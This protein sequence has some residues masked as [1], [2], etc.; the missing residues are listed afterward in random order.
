MRNAE[1]QFL[2]Q[3]EVTKNVLGKRVWSKIF[4]LLFWKVQD[5]EWNCVVYE[6][7]IFEKHSK[8]SV[9]NK[10]NEKSMF[11]MLGMHC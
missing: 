10:D 5:F 9:S 1:E 4:I 11:V 6:D 8:I 7:F 3:T 2:E